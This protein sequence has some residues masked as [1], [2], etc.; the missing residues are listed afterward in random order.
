MSKMQLL[1]IVCAL[2]T[3]YGFYLRHRNANKDQEIPF[4]LGFCKVCETAPERGHC[5]IK[6]NRNKGFPTQKSDVSFYI[7]YLKRVNAVNQE[8]I[9]MLLIYFDLSTSII[10]QLLHIQVMEMTE[11]HFM[12]QHD[13]KKLAS[14]CLYKKVQLI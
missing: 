6:A 10:L 8:T 12:Y 5:I 3:Q 2:P 1:S 9:C 4:L 7:S 13:L 14:S 11:S